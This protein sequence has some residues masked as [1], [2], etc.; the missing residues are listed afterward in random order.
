M[1]GS[2]KMTSIRSICVYCGS[3]SGA[4]GHYANLARDFGHMLAGHHITLVYGGGGIGLMGTLARAVKEHGGKVIGVI[5]RHLDQIEI[6][7]PGLDEMHVV[8]DMHTRKRKMF[9]LSDAF[10]SLPGSIGTLDET[11]EVITWRQLGLHDKPIILVNDG[12]YWNPFLDLLQHI[13]KE[14]FAND[15]LNTLYEVVDS[16]HDV[17]P[18]LAKEPAPRIIARNRLI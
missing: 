16:I 12:G 17:L 7:Q 18:L 2:Q 14:G 15:S 1:T 8:D 13:Q 10:V 9:D 11:I 5:P 6:K 4:D 3:R